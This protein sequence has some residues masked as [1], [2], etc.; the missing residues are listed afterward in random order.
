MSSTLDRAGALWIATYG[1]GVWRYDGQ[2][3]THYPV[4]SGDQAIT[5]FTISQDTRGLLWLG[6]Q[7]EGPYRFNGESFEKFR[8]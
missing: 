7:N 1:E 3:T 5:L 2:S 8:P 4:T 6:T